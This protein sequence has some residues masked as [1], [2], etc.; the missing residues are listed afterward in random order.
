MGP[1]A[2]AR[3]ASVIRDETRQEQS[4]DSADGLNAKSSDDA[5]VAD[6]QAREDKWVDDFCDVGNSSELNT[7]AMPPD[8]STALDW[9]D[10]FWSQDPFDG[11]YETV[12]SD[13]SDVPTISWNDEAMAASSVNEKPPP[14]YDFQ[15]AR[16]HSH[17]V[18]EWAKIP[19]TLDARSFPAG[20]NVSKALRRGD[21][22]AESHV[23]PNDLELPIPE[24]TVGSDQLTTLRGDAND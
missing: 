13:V 6:A 3:E 10:I 15:P 5:G 21:D 20:I 22:P 1:V 17:P 4:Q 8:K 9:Q 12:A 14:M 23:D 16:F 24:A 18:P 2:E 7:E 19:G 11:Q